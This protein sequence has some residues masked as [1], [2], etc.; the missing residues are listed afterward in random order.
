MDATGLDAAYPVVRA[1]A[2]GQA[3]QISV[4]QIVMLVLAVAGLTIVMLSTR[5][6][7]RK[8]HR[9]SPTSTRERFSQLQAQRET[10]RDLEQVMLELDQLS[11]QIHGRIDTKLA[12]LE[13]L[14]RDADGRI[15]RLSEL[16]RAAKGESTLEI[17][18]GSEDPHAVPPTPSDVE[19]ERHEA[20]Y[21]LADSGQSTAQI[22][23]EVDKTTGEIELIL[24][25]RRV[26]QEG[27]R[28][29]AQTIPQ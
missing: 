22:A 12:R 11:R 28:S 25:L 18:P 27:S 16:I 21:R 13:A 15:E 7:V 23:K 26:R 29:T 8:S 6:R 14:M 4:P 2:L 9:Q 24:A 10:T 20:I 5:R 17:T 1:I 3:S 19:D